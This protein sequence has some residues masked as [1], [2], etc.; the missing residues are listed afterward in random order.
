MTFNE[1]IGNA[2]KKA[3]VEKLLTTLQIEMRYGIN[4]RSMQRYEKSID[5][6]ETLRYVCE[7]LKVNYMDILEEAEKI[8]TLENK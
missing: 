4:Q 7:Q 8:L 5:S 2:L 6:I 1:A 3:R